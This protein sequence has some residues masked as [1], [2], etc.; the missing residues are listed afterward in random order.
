MFVRRRIH[1]ESLNVAAS[2]V[3]G[4]HRFT[5]VINET[6]DVA[7]K[8]VQQIDKQVDVFK[9][10]FHTN[11]ELVWQQQVLCKVTGIDTNQATENALHAHGARRINTGD[12]Y[13]VYEVTGA[14]ETTAAVVEMLEPFGIT[15]MVKSARIAVI[16]SNLGI[17]KKLK[18]IEPLNTCLSDVE[19]NGF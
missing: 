4:I 16:K 1:I 5:I 3:E 14:A 7:R 6:E 18:Q 19:D 9:T 2:E 15:E 11:E 17:R 12:E 8:L 13:T 10:F